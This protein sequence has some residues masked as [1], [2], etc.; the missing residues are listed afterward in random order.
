MTR[1]MDWHAL[2]IGEALRQ[3]A[4]RDPDRTALVGM[5]ARMS[6]AQLDRAA[7]EVAHGLRALGV[8]RGDQVALW[9]TNSPD[10]VVCWMACTRIG[11]VL[12]PVNTRFKLEEVAYILRQSDARVLIAMDAYWGI[13]F[14]SMIDTFVPGL[15]DAQPG[16]LQSPGLPELRA[17]VLWNSVQA[18]GT[19]HL[20]ALRAEGARR[21]AAGEQLPAA[22]PNDAVII[23]YTSGTTGHPK[24]AMHGHIVMRNALL[25]RG[26]RVHRGDPHDP[27]GLHAGDPA[28]LGARRS[29]GNHRAR[30]R[31]HFR[32]HSHA[33]HRLPGRHPTPSA[34]C[35]LPE[36]GLDWRCA[37]HTRRRPGRQTGTWF[38]G[39]AGG[40][41]DDRN[42][43][44]HGVQ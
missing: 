39:A 25:S 4:Q 15:H 33:F 41:R 22:D 12:V 3:T 20:N 1:P 37:G 30:A 10:W 28:A 27:V 13:D 26:R 43:C 34:R 2:T 24:G 7:D 14:L 17:V 11:A 5:G 21:M 32:R 35:V 16:R 6:F 9:L 31:H 40:L 29:A 38:A 18:P 23:V 8:A 44:G 36:V 42:H 19:T